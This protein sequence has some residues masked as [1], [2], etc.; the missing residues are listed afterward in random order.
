[1]PAAAAGAGTGAGAHT[2]R[3]PRRLARPAAA[4]AH[5]CAAPSAGWASAH[6]LPQRWSAGAAAGC[7]RL[8]PPAPAPG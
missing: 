2:P 1:M 7:Q 6:A 4:A 3:A 8:P 5:G